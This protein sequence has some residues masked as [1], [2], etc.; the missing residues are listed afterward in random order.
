[1]PLMH[2]RSKARLICEYAGTL[3]PELDLDDATADAAMDA[4][5]ELFAPVAIHPH[6]RNGYTA[7]LITMP[8][9]QSATEA[10]LV[11]ILHK[12][13][14]PHEYM[15]LSPSTRYFVLEKT[16]DAGRTVMCEWGRD[17]TH[18]NYGVGTAPDQEAFAV[19]V[20]ERVGIV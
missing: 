4:E 17:E 16:F 14:E 12:D 13:D 19:A 5:A 6:H 15:Q 3:P 7:Y 2:F 8:T 1:M 11:A 9:P 10:H 18:A 20:F